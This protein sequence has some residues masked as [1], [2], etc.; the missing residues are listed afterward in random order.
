MI[1]IVDVCKHFECREGNTLC[2]VDGKIVLERYGA[3]E[4]YFPH[5]LRHGC[6]VMGMD[7]WNL[8]FITLISGLGIL[9]S[10][11]ALPYIRA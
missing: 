4:D 7:R 9:L 2:G 8:Y 6:E 3:A 11:K 1:A 5:N 10:I